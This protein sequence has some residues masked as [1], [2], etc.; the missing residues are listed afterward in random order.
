[1]GTITPP[2]T[3]MATPRARAAEPPAQVQPPAPRNEQGMNEDTVLTPSRL[4]LDARVFL[5]HTTLSWLCGNSTFVV[6]VLFKLRGAT[7]SWETAFIPLFLSGAATIAVQ[8]YCL[9]HRQY[10]I[11][12]QLGPPPLITSSARIHLQYSYMMVVRNRSH[13]ID[14]I[15]N[16]VEAVAVIAA[17]AAL[18]Y[19]FQSGRLQTGQVALRLLFTPI[20][21]A[22]PVTSFLSCLKVRNERSM[23]GM[24]DFF[25]V[26]CLFIAC[27]VDGI[28]TW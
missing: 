9:F 11:F 27:E 24:H 12:N 1:M 19:G 4:R 15:N 13:T 18:A 14:C 20:W 23:G 2:V 8:S 3:P 6:L 26:F 25:F 28:T 5:I 17:E 10:F 21:V 7:Y 16:I 22:W